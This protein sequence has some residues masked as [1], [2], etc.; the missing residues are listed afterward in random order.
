MTNNVPFKLKLVIGKGY[1]HYGI[2]ANYSFLKMLNP[3]Y[4]HSDNA[5]QESFS[6]TFSEYYPNISYNLKIGYDR[7]INIVDIKEL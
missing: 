5:Y 4:I 7:Y 3:A 6:I 2:K 1:K